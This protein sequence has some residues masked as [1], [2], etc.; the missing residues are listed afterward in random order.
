MSLEFPMPTHLIESHPLVE[1][2]RNQVAIKRGP[3]VYC[4]ESIDLPPGVRV[5]EVAVN[6]TT[7]FTPSRDSQMLGGITMLETELV[8]QKVKEWSSNLYRPRQRPERSIIPTRLVPYFAWSN[9]G[10]S[11]M[12]VWLPLVS[13]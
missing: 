2:T 13:E 4:L 11:E 6:P 7:P 12:S 10:E 1:E 8:H 5:R 3:I 9:R